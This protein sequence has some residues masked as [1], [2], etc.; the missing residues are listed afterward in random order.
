MTLSE[1]GK[2]VVRAS[3]ISDCEIWVITTS[4]SPG[5]EQ[6]ESKFPAINRIPSGL[7]RLRVPG[8]AQFA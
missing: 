8:R 3:K 6:I 5:E 2:E 1:E 4:R 7:K